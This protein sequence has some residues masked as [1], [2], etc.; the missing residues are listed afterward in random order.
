MLFVVVFIVLCALIAFEAVIM[1]S[2]CLF[3]LF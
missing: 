2:F 1:L 3:L